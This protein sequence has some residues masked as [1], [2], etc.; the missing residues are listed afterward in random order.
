VAKDACLP[1]CLIELK[2][3][4][5]GKAVACMT[6]TKALGNI[7]DDCQGRLI[8]LDRLQLPPLTNVA[9]VLF[10]FEYCSF[11]ESLLELLQCSFCR[12]VAALVLGV[13]CASPCGDP[14]DITNSSRA[15]CIN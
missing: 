15:G 11:A 12:A 7:V 14:C 1:A 4:A 2:I 8:D 9:A 10:S 13:E 3:A 6:T 5:V